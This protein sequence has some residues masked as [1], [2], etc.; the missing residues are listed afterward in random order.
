[1]S[2]SQGRSGGGVSD[3]SKC[4]K[5]LGLLQGQR[6]SE[7]TME[8]QGGAREGLGPRLGAQAGSQPR[9]HQ[10]AGYPALSL[11]ALP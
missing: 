10:K 6:Q 7:L 3:T 2:Q 1:M 5:V 11:W 9:Q 8:S 4:S